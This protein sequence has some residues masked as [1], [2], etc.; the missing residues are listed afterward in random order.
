VTPDL[1]L[2]IPCYNEAEHLEDSV[3]QLVEVLDGTRYDYEVVFVDD[4]STDGTRD[5]LP[6]VCAGR[7]RLRY[8]L[9]EQNRG[10][11]GAF[12]T[13]FAAARGRITGYIDIDLEVHAR[14]IP[15]LVA[16]IDKHGIDVATGYRHYLLSQTG[17]LHRELLSMG[18]R[19]LCRLLLGLGV[20]DSETG[21]KFFKRE[22]AAGVV[23]GSQSD[24]WFWDTEVM[25]RAALAGLSIEELPVLFLRRVDKTSTVRLLRDVRGYLVE[26]YR[27]RGKVGLSLDRSPIYWSTFL[28]DLAM[29]LLYGRAYREIYAGV[30]AL[31]PEGDSV[32]D[33]CAGTCR[34][35]LDH[36]KARRGDYLAL[37][38]N[39]HFVMAARNR[40]V[41]ARL[42][43]ITREEVPTAD[44]VVMCSSF[45]HFHRSA[46]EVLAK[47]RAAARKGVIVSEPVKNLSSHSLRPL[48]AVARWLTRPG[49]GSDFAF[50]FDLDGFRGFAEEHGAERFVHS[51]GQRNAVAIFPGADAS[52]RRV[53][54]G[55]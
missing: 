6:R 24:G 41:N 38:Y 13:G 49:R 37:D 2:A 43:D 52:S 12:K 36:L 28:Y 35:Y 3:R 30:A 54:A 10:R 7:P 18:Y 27:F 23:L 53:A 29:R 5:L 33:V 15:A 20:R 4:G 42:F 22:T 11:G 39:G 31:I 1:S 16:L 47:M 19:F 45:Y 25:S 46:P 44:W 34:L 17:G 40:G 55:E 32:A 26:L 8:L 50:R 48:A 9:H 21:C 51:P 14:Y